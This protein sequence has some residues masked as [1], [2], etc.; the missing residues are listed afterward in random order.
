MS[1]AGREVANNGY[2]PIDQAPNAHPPFTFL[3]SAGGQADARPAPIRASHAKD[4]PQVAMQTNPGQRTYRYMPSAR[5]RLTAMGLSLAICLGIGLM[6]IWMGMIGPKPG[7]PRNRLEAV[8][9]S[10]DPVKKVGGTQAAAKAPP[11]PV[12]AVP[13]EI[14]PPQAVPTP[15]P[16]VMP[17]LDLS[18]KTADAVAS[19]DLGKLPKSAGGGAAGSGQSGAVAYGPGEGPGGARLYRAE[20]YRE[21]TDAEIAGYMPQRQI[22][23]EWATIAC[24]T[25]ERYHVENCQE[26]GESPRGSGLARAMRQAA[27]Q[28]LVRPPR[29]DGKPLVGA[30]VSIRIDFKRKPARDAGGDGAD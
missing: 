25:V 21:P 18:R 12:R 3:K 5:S 15:K 1:E 23:A 8:S 28:F 30:W 16:V 20:W 7:A 6:L 29:I 4:R 9:I 14:A 13:S 19:F 26:L 10:T 27:W 11:A 22:D 24:R 2:A 17:R